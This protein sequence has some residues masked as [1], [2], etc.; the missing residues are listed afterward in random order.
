MLEAIASF[1]NVLK[2]VVPRLIDLALSLSY[3]IAT[4]PSRLVI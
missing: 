1:A 2:I 3:D 4:A